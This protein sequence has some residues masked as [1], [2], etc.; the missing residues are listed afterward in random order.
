M[1]GNVTQKKGCRQGKTQRQGMRRSVRSRLCGLLA[2]LLLP[3]AS[4]VVSAAELAIGQPAPDFT[5]PDETGMTH[6]L[7]DYRGHTVILMFY[8]KDFTS[9]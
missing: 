3:M 1:V 8:P 9:G 4:P 2:L 7:S 5:L 6:R